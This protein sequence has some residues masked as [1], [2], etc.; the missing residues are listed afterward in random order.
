MAKT[1]KETMANEVIMEKEVH[2]HHFHHFPIMVDVVLDP[3]EDNNE[4]VSWNSGNR[5]NSIAQMIRRKTQREFQHMVHNHA[6][7]Y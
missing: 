5:R 1:S 3:A 4:C 6:S 2:L 7:I